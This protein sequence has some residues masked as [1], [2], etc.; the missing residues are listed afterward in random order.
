M[1][2]VININYFYKDLVFIY[3]INYGNKVYYNNIIST[4]FN[5]RIKFNLSKTSCLRVLNKK[6]KDK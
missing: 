2:K 4:L 6:K 1:I 3:I 5:Y